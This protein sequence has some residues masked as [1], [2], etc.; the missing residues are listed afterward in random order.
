MERSD[1]P[2]GASAEGSFLTRIGSASAR[3]FGWIAELTLRRWRAIIA[4]GTIGLSILFLIYLLASHHA[5]ADFGVYHAALMQYR[6]IGTPYDYKSLMSTYGSTFPFIYAPIMFQTFVALSWLF[7]SRVGQVLLIAMDL[8]AC[9]GLWI[10]LM[11]PR[12]RPPA[13]DFAW[14]MEASLVAF[15]F[16]GLKLFATGNSQPFLLFALV[17]TLFWSSRI[18]NYLPFW[19]ALVLVV[20]VKMYLICIGMVPFL[21]E[22]KTWQLGL[23]I[24]AAAGVYSLNY[25]TPPVLLHGYTDSLSI[26]A[27]TYVGYSITSAAQMVFSHVHAIGPRLVLPIALGVQAVYAAIL[28]AFAA[29]VTWTKARPRDRHY[30]FFV[31]VHGRHA[32]IAASSHL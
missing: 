11:P 23:A 1:E 9:L 6:A 30:A 13:R 5:F 24:V 8:A 17:G 32:D 18:K 2:L 4:I 29:A 20:Q 27:N 21:L 10:T 3:F 22:R 26:A 15:G 28:M 16:Y 14:L 25:L 19:V 7:E 12:F 31:G